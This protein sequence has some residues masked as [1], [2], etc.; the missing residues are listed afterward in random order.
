M[1]GID[2][3][4]NA[5]VLV[6]DAYLWVAGSGPLEKKL[7]TQMKRLNLDKRVKFLGWREDNEKLMA[8]AD[9]CVFPSRN[10]S[11]GAVT[12]ESWAAKKTIV[13]CKSPGPLATISHMNDGVLV[14]IDNIQ[15]LAKALNNLINNRNLIEKLAENGYKKFKKNYTEKVFGNN[16]IDIYTKILPKK[17]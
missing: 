9:I 15:Q 8:T 5:M 16:I 14:E 3:L 10:D 17:S 12:I 1:K 11:F 13:A 4:L 2:I 7:K 6:P